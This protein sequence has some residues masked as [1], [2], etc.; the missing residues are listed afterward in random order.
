MS[1]QTY[2]TPSFAPWTIVIEKHCWEYRG[3]KGT[4]PWLGFLL[5]CH[6]CHCYFCNLIVYGFFSSYK[7]SLFLSLL[8]SSH[9]RW[10]DELQFE[11]FGKKSSFFAIKYSNLH[12]EIPS[13]QIV[14]TCTCDDSQTKSTHCFHI[15]SL[16][17]HFCAV[18]VWTISELPPWPLP[19]WSDLPQTWLLPVVLPVFSC[20][21]SCRYL[22]LFCSCEMLWIFEF[23]E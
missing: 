23:K 14:T 4:N 19:S 20:Q 1:R 11:I 21:R 16:F 12:S 18:A 9:W 15:P 3:G 13:N 22:K 8:I 17:L 7:F 10:I 5:L 6:R 2:G